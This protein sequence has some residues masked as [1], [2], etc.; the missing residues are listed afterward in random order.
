MQLKYREIVAANKVSV[1]EIKRR[2]H[3]I[4]KDTGRAAVNR[5]RRS[6]ERTKHLVIGQ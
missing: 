4:F 3:I 5:G 2:E 6:S 1:Y